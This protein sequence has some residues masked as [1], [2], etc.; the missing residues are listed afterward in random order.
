MN[1]N[2]AEDDEL[3]SMGYLNPRYS[4]NLPRNSELNNYQF[5]NKAIQKA[6]YI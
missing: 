2:V 3:S 4:N 6:S 1:Q 5:L